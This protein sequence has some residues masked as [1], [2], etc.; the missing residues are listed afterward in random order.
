MFLADINIADETLA[1]ICSRFGVK[2]L[3]VF[4]S[5]L[6]EDFSTN[7]DIDF[8]V[9]FEDDDAGPWLEKFSDLELALGAA[10]SRSVDVV[11]RL[12]VEESENYIRRKHILDS[13]VDIYVA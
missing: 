10:L 1:A 2:R 6:R 9:E 5:A 4:G 12:A 8:L 13:A 11:D 7:S 3:A